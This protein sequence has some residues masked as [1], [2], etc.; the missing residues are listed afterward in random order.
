MLGGGDLGPRGDDSPCKQVHGAL[1]VEET[2]LGARRQQLT[3]SERVDV[4]D[5]HDWR[6]VQEGGAGPVGPGRGDE[7]TNIGLHHGVYCL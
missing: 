7:L 5:A 2:R 1:R 4:E 3:V 6:L